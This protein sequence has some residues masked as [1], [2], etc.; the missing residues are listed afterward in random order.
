MDACLEYRDGLSP[1]APTG[2]RIGVVLFAAACI[3]LGAC[4]ALPVT[5][6]EAEARPAI[7]PVPIP[8]VARIVPPAPRPVSAPVT[9]Q[10]PAPVTPEPPT[11]IGLLVS[12]DL[13][14]YSGVASRL[15]ELLGPDRVDIRILDEF[16]GTREELADAILISAPSSVVAIG[17]DAALFAASEL[18]LP[19]VFCQVLNYA[20]H[21]SLR[22]AAAGVSALPSIS[23]QF[24]YWKN[25]DAKL[26][27]VGTIA[28]PGHEDLLAEASAAADE[29][30]LDFRH[31]ISQSDQETIY[32]FKRLA[33]QIDG[34]WLIPDNR[35]LSLNAIREILSYAA[36]REIRVVVSNPGLLKFGALMS[37]S[38][39]PV[40]IADAVFNVIEALASGEQQPFEVFRPT[41]FDVEINPA[42][43]ERFGIDF[44]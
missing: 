10:R 14:A 34:F 38:L 7:E 2:M 30:N 37:L 42:V 33:T 3:L 16:S 28:G 18:D 15:A 1:V 27:R 17:L 32:L 20:E 11:R 35:I 23:Q 12:S 44:D 22:H 41:R 29:Q 6:P 31:R 24:R 5:S 21:E 39:T 19:I 8:L 25:V 40:Q 4:S 9:P 36:E 43:A 26:R 13:P